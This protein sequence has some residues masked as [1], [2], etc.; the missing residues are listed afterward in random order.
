MRNHSQTAAA[1]AGLALIGAFGLTA[2]SGTGGASG[3]ADALTVGVTVA[4]S[5]NPFFQAETATAKSYGAEQGLEVLSQVADEDVQKQSNQ[6]DQF[7]TSGVDFIVV[8]AADTDGVGPAVKRAVEAGIPVIGV[9]NQSKNASVNIT[10]DNTQ[11]GEISCQS[12]AEQLDGAGKIAILNG[13]PVSAVDDRVAGCKEALKAFPDIEIV[14]D[15]RGENSRDSA[16]PLATDILTANPDLDGFF[17]INDP[18]AA[19]VMLAAKQK[20]ADIIITSVD[21]A[22]DATDVIADQGMI[23]AT[24]AQDPAALMREAIDTGMKLV[25]GEQ[26][27]EP[28]ILVPTTLI[29]ASNVAEYEPWG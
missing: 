23:T 27:A 25:G 26:A 14:A 13:T 12:L 21:G 3:D 4:N 15:Q 24:S 16:L 9:D 1:L 7:V 18:S 22:A 11:A 2:C 20:G 28:L 10:T 6:I 8:D 19:G 17:A 29:D 5:T